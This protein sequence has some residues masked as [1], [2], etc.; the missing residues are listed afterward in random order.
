MKRFL[1]LL[2]GVA[3]LHSHPEQPQ[4]VHGKASLEVSSPS[5]LKIRADDKAVIHWD[6]F[7]I[8]A[9]EVAQFIQP[10][11]QAAV[12]NKVV[13]NEASHLL[14]SLQANGK[15]YL[16]NPQGIIIGKDAQINTAA[17]IASSLDLMEEDFLAGKDLCFKGESL[18][19]VENYGT[20]TAVDGDALLIGYRV[21]DEGVMKADSGIAALAAGLEVLVQPLGEE[22]IFIRPVVGPKADIGVDQKGVLQ[23]MQAEIKA[24]GGLYSLAIRSEGKIDASRV[25]RKEGRVF[26]VSEKGNAEVKGTISAETIRVLAQEI[27]VQDSALLDASGET[28]GGSIWVGGDPE[29]KR[30]DIPH[31]QNITIHKGAQLS[32]DALTQG[33][34]GEVILFAE[35][36][37]QFHGS[38]SARG[39]REGGDGGFIE[40]SGRRDVTTTG[41]VST[42]APQGKD[43]KFLLDPDSI[44]IMINGGVNSNITLAPDLTLAT[45]F[46]YA[47]NP[48][49]LATAKPNM[50]VAILDVA[51]LVSYLSES[52]V[53]VSTHKNIGPIGGDVTVANAIAWTSSNT[54][55]L[56]ADGN[57]ILDDGISCSMAGNLVLFAEGTITIH[58][59]GVSPGISL[60]GGA[61]PNNFISITTDAFGTSMGDITIEAPIMIGTGNID[62]ET[63]L[64]FGTGVMTITNSIGCKTE[65][66]VLIQSLGN[67]S[68]G[69]TTM[70]NNVEIFTPFGGEGTLAGIQINS[71]GTLTIQGSNMGPFH[72]QVGSNL[73]TLNILA[74]PVHEI[75]CNIGV[76]IFTFAQNNNLML[77][78]GTADDAYAQ[79]G[80]TGGH[81][82]NTG[83]TATLSGQ[84]IVTVAGTATITGSTSG[85]RAYAQIGHTP[86]TNGGISTVIAS[87]AA[88]L[89]GFSTLTLTGGAQ[90]DTYA[91]IGHG[92]LST[93]PNQTTTYQV[94]TVQATIGGP[95]PYALSADS[96]V[97]AVGTAMTLNGGSAP[98]SFAAIGITGS[99]NTTFMNCPFDVTV[100]LLPTAVQP[101]IGLTAG[102]GMPNAGAH[103]G[104]FLYGNNAMAV[105]S[106]MLHFVN[107][108]LA[109]SA[110]GAGNITL[111]GPSVPSSSFAAIGTGN[112]LGANMAA[113]INIE[114][115]SIVPT[116]TASLTLKAM[117]GT[118]GPNG[119]GGAFIQ[120]GMGAI[121]A[122]Q[123]SF[124]YITIM[125]DVTVVAGM[126][127]SSYISGLGNVL[128]I[129]G[130]NIGITTANVAFP[131]HI[132]CSFNNLMLVTDFSAGSAVGPGGFSLDANSFVKTTPPSPPGT[133]VYIWTAQPS[134]NTVNGMINNTPFMNA[135]TH[136]N[137]V[138][139]AGFTATDPY[140]IFYKAP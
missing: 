18:A 129:A 10:S 21:L 122:F 16:I 102:N 127:S 2:A 36:D 91:L 94:Q 73:D 130:N 23:A 113:N 53:E 92:G 103:I 49:N 30:S 133:P 14:G 41:K 68:I 99:A 37:A 140:A 88:S 45:T 13:G 51:N 29:G 8:A 61:I 100:F 4:V 138:W 121:P 43:G 123:K 50:A 125:E 28:G 128:I 39:G 47:G 79:I 93:A 26:L 78:A 90:T 3:F 27:E 59:T 74:P 83:M 57:I 9:G 110:A 55:M 75:D 120:N 25:E 134:Q 104:V 72:V 80:H 97:G 38:A 15:V 87:S 118:P 81:S 63:D 22:R 126:N 48:G 132:N 77:L 131:G 33:N 112:S 101:S 20:I 67:M 70:M 52:N 58:N 85:S 65:G 106:P 5:H 7:S 11:S 76:D 135:F 95:P 46:P 105:S 109:S 69:S 56:N 44:T 86:S 114:S 40:L 66:S 42:K 64:N 107:I 124:T 31:A 19:S 17:F 34:G 89:G 35:G 62:I 1:S 139:H 24:D 32:A 115:A 136:F 6:K 60:A 82:I 137:T 116:P 71:S 119:E 98:G 117:N 96:F 54:L 108:F 111:T 84:C 12:L